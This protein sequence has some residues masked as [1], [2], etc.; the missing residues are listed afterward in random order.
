[1]RTD[2]KHDQHGEGEEYPFSQFFNSE[3]V[4]DDFKH[5]GLF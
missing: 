4:F 1:M 3:Y 2:T 5:I